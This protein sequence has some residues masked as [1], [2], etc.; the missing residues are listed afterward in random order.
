MLQRVALVASLALLV[1]QVNAQ[2]P[3]KA[4]PTTAAKPAET[5]DNTSSDSP[6]PAGTSDTPQT[7]ASS[8]DSSSAPDSKS[9]QQTS[10]ANL[11]SVESTPTGALPQISSAPPL[12]GLSTATFPGITQNPVN[13]PTYQVVIPSNDNNPFLQTSGFP[14]GTVFIVV[15][16]AL[17]GLALMLIAWRAIYIW[18]LHIQT[19]KQRKTLKYS[20]MEQ[21]PYTAVNGNANASPFSGGNISLDYLRPGDRRSQTSVYS[22][23]RPSTARPLTSIMRPPSNGHA[24]SAANVQFYSPSAYPGGTPA[25]ALGTA[26]SRDSYLPPGRY[27]RDSSSTNVSTSSAQSRQNLNTPSTNPFLLSD[28]SSA[29]IARLSRTP[30]SNSVNTMAGTRPATSS[31]GGSIYGGSS[32]RP[33]SAYKDVQ[34]YSQARR[35]PSNYSDGYTPDRRSKPSQALDELLGGRS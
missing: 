6:T 18:C 26:S 1:G 34:G 27:M 8:G 33:I 2:K 13:I 30:T 16:S 31:A 28:P 20:E 21:R 35:A 22:T 3:A 5:S 24:L 29:P 10:S 17:A 19:K 12:P 7:P 4:T 14:E 32:S 11:P 9:R 25:A 15:G 23:T